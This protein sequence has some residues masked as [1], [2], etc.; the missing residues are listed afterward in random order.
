MISCGRKKGSKKTHLKT[1]TQEL[2]VHRGEGAKLG[3]QRVTESELGKGVGGVGGC[4]YKKE[5]GKKDHDRMAEKVMER[6][7]KK[8]RTKQRKKWERE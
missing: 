2:T 5:R 4:V 6:A 1:Q 7:R 8:E 3:R